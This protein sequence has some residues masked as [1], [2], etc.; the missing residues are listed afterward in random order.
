MS[1][2]TLVKSQ[3]YI[4][5]YLVFLVFGTD[6]QQCIKSVYNLSAGVPGPK[7]FQGE[8]GAPGAKGTFKALSCFHFNEPRVN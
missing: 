1:Q 5:S 3:F 7:G 4:I 6:W 8:A 2:E